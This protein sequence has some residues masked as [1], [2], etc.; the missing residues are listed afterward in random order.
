MVPRTGFEPVRLSTRD[1]KSRAS[2]VSPPGRSLTPPGRL[3]PMVRQGELALVQFNQSVESTSNR[4][5]IAIGDATD[6]GWP[7]GLRWHRCNDARPVDHFEQSKRVGGRMHLVRVVEVAVNVPGLGGR[8]KVA[9]D[10]LGVG[11]ATA[12]APYLNPLCP[13]RP[14]HA[15][16]EKAGTFGTD[17]RGRKGISSGLHCLHD[18]PRSRL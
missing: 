15:G 8:L 11:R 18:E 3:C 5:L 1:F 14:G 9:C 2:T 6:G 16:T 13:A 7:D 10:D 17:K 4:G 12:G